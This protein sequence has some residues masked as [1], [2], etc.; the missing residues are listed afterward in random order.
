MKFWRLLPIL[1]CAASAQAS[2]I[3]AGSA[4]R[5]DVLA[6]I[7]AALLDGD[8][9]QI[10]NGNCTWTQTI[11]VSL[12]RSITIQG[13][14]AISSTNGGS[15][16]TGSDATIILDHHPTVG[17]TLFQFDIA[18]GKT[19]RI[20]GIRFSMD[21]SS[22]ST[23][24]GV[25]YVSG[26]SNSVRIDHNHFTTNP[27]GSMS[28]GVYGG[29]TGVIDHNYFDSELGNGPFAVYL[30][31]GTGTGDA[32]W[33]APDDFGTDKFI[34]IEDNRWRNGYLGDANTGG[35]RFV[36]RYNTGVMQA[37]DSNHTI[38]YV[39]NHGITSGRS[40]SSRAFEYYGNVFSAVAPGLNKSPF[41][42]NGGTALVWGNTISQY[43]YVTS[44][45][46]TRK[47]NATYPYGSPPSGW[48]N[49]NGSSGTVW[50]G[51]G[52]Y[53]CLDQP[54]RGRGD[55]LSGSFPNIINTRTGNA[56]YVQQALSPIYVWANTL[57][58]AGYSG[59]PIVNFDSAL[60]LANRDFYQ[61]FGT[62]GE[63]GSFN[64][65]A[66]V[67]QGLL[68]ARP[69]TC[70]S[71]V[72]YW[73]TDTSRLYVCGPA[74]TWTAYYVPYE[75]PHPLAGGTPLP[76]A[77][78]TATATAS[79]TITPTPTPTATPPFTSAGIQEVGN[80]SQRATVAASGADM[81]MK[82]FAGDITAGNEIIVAGAAWALSAAITTVAVTDSRSTSYTVVMGTDQ[83]DGGHFRT[84]IARGFPIASGPCVVTVNPQGAS[85]DFS[86][87]QD[88]FLGVNPSVSYNGTDVQGTMV[89][90]TSGT[91]INDHL[92]LADA[93]IVGV[94]THGNQTVALSPG[95]GHVT[96]GK[97][98]NNSGGQAHIAIFRIE[99]APNALEFAP[100][101][102]NYA[103]GAASNH[104]WT[105]QTYGFGKANTP[106]DITDPAIPFS[107]SSSAF[108]APWRP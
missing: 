72:G 60:I 6:A 93:L 7:N 55:L 23:Q 20:A 108:Q 65:T 57:D 85:A 105:F 59:T 36:Y 24:N 51:P 18:S 19:L 81:A 48:G 8:I 52:G 25:I 79:P 90:S 86:F 54:G 16:T 78:P 32:A 106:F 38:G 45:N 88:E 83:N 74:N 15:G 31:N 101:I 77:T 100:H 107:N 71:G 43:R 66:G 58:P 87:T 37:D 13:T 4:C 76:T 3:V 56:A 104:P 17:H 97:I 42:I 53:P 61:Q 91:A 12:N 103:A 92:S 89:A 62:N 99:P 94:M 11:N 28:I 40:R 67:G 95:D 63:P 75:Y 2:T 49:C 14:G 21:G 30:Q 10:P 9:V 39:A 96:F 68:S 69:A 73:A 44:L 29:V 1:F 22:V 5:D 26:G 80:G 35:Q 84:F 102:V 41:P 47:D 98:E 34:F 70:T 46:Y 50:D 27:D 82:S 64:G 33:N